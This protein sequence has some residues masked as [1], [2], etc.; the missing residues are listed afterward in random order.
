ML[1]FFIIVCTN[2]LN[3]NYII[4]CFFPSKNQ[5]IFTF[6]SKPLMIY[7]ILF[8]VLLLSPIIAKELTKVNKETKCPKYS[9]QKF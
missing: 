5:R 8:Q 6:H 3:N 7:Q 2:K 4:S 9:V 1:L